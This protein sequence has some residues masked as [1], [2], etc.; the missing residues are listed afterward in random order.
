MSGLYTQPALRHCFGIDKYGVAVSVL[1]AD[2]IGDVHVVEFDARQEV[3][4]AVDGENHLTDGGDIE[5]ESGGES[6]I[7]AQ[8]HVNLTVKR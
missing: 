4:E 8:V 1:A 6:T 7:A 3:E 2:S 5:V